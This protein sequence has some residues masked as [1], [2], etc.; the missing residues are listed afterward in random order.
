[1]LRKGNLLLIFA[2]L[3]IAAGCTSP[4]SQL[5]DG[6]DSNSG[7]ITGG[8]LKP[9]LDKAPDLS[10][11]KVRYFEPGKTIVDEGKI[12][13]DDE[14]FTVTGYGPVD[15]LPAEVK[16][17]S[18]YVTF[19]QPV[20]PLS[21][22]G[23]PSG[24][25]D[26]LTI[27]PPLGGVYRWY[28]T[29][30]LSFDAGED[31]IAQRRYT[32][33]VAPSVRSLGG[34]SLSE[35]FTF[36]FR[37]EPLSIVQIIPGDDWNTDLSDV[38][39]GPARNVTVLFSHPVNPDVVTAYI[40]VVVAGGSVAFSFDRRF[41]AGL[42]LTPE[43]HERALVLRL[44]KEVEEETV[45]EIVL[46]E[47]A[48]SQADYLGS[49]AEQR[50][51][52]MTLGK[53][54]FLDYDTYSW[55]FP[56][57]PEGGSYPVF[58]RFSHPVDPLGLS[59]K[60]VTRPKANIPPEAV[61][62]WEG[63]VMIS[64]L[65]FPPEST[66]TLI[67]SPEIRD[68]YA[69]RLGT[70]VKNKVKVPEAQSYSYFPNT[71]SRMLEAEFPH[72][73]AY[74]YQNVF[75]GVWKIDRITDPYRSFDP[76]E[77][78]AYDFSTLKKNVRHFEVLDL[79][80]WLNE[81]GKGTVGISWN[82]A[83]L[84]KD[85]VRPSW[86]QDDLQ[87]QV[88]DL[89]ITA[90]I[91]YNRILVLVTSL[92]TGEPVA[93][94]EVAIMR[95]QEVKLKAETDRSGVAAFDLEAG[96]YNR[97]FQDYEKEWRDHLR[98]RAKI[99]LDSIEFV[100]N[101]S[102]N[103]YRSGVY[104]VSSP[105]YA[106]H[107]T[108]ET[109]LFTDRGLYRPGEKLMFRGID[110]DL[111]L[112]EYKPYQ[113]AYAVKLKNSGYG[114]DV[115]AAL[116][117]YTSFSGGLYGSFDLPGEMEPGYYVIEYTRPD[118]RQWSAY[119]QIAFF[120]NLNF[121]VRI[122]GPDTTRYLGDTLEYDVHAGYLSGGNLSGGSY[123]LYWTKEPAFFSPPGSKWDGYRFGPL[124]SDQ[125]QFLSSSEGKLDSAGN[126]RAEQ[127]TTA[128]GVAGMPYTYQ[129]EAR[130]QNAG[131]QEI[132][133]KKLS[134]VHP[135][136]FYIG[137]R[138]STRLK[139]ASSA[140][141]STGEELLVAWV[142][143]DP[144]GRLYDRGVKERRIEAELFRVDWKIAQQQGVGG[145]VTTRYEMVEELE[146]SKQIEDG[147]V[148]G[149][150]NFTPSRGGLYRVRLNTVDDTGRSVATGLEFYATG[151]DWIRWGGDSDEIDL[152]TD[153]E[154][155]VPGETANI[156]VKS[157]LPKG[158][159]IVTVEREGIFDEH[160]LDLEGSAQ[161]IGVPIREEY[162]PIVYVSVASYSV[163][164]GAPSHTY[165]TPDLD[166]PKGYFGVVP[167]VVDPSSRRIDIDIET[168]G[169]A[170]LPG[171]KAEIVIRATRMKKP[172]AGAE[173]TFLAVDRGVVDLID[174]H[175]PDP[176]EFF[177]S[178]SKFPLY[179]KGA[180]SRSLLIDP[181]T[182]EVRDQFGGDAEDGKEEGGTRS[183]FVP[184][185]V[186]EPFLITDRDGVARVVFTLP[187]SLTTYRCTAVAV[188]G[189]RFGYSEEELRVQQP[190]N[191][192]SL[193]PK[194]IRVRDTITAGVMV[195][196]MDRSSHKVTIGVESNLVK[197]DGEGEKTVNVKP[198]ATLEV[199]FNLYAEEPG[200]TEV[201]F[202]T[203]S[204]VLTERL[205]RQMTVERPAVRETVTTTG[206]I[207]PGDASPPV[208]GVVI[209][210]YEAV[211]DGKLRITLSPSLL[212][213]LFPAVEYLL[214]YPHGC[215]EQRASRL[216]PV[217]LFGSSIVENPESFVAEELKFWAK[218]QLGSGGFP[219]WP[220]NGDHASYYVTVRIA[221][222]LKIAEA[223]G[224]AIPDTIDRRTLVSY[225][226]RPD[227]WVSSNDYLLLYSLYVQSLYGV[228]VHRQAA[229]F[230]ARSNELNHASHAFL[231][232]IFS[233]LRLPVKAAAALKGIIRYLKPG[234]RSVDLTPKGSSP[235]FFY[236]DI[237]EQLAL[238]LMLQTA[239]DPGSDLTDRI[240]ASLLTERHGGSWTNTAATN[241]ALLSLS[242]L[243]ERRD[244]GVPNMT[245]AVTLDKTEL[246]SG[247]FQRMEDSAAVEIR[248]DEEPVSLVKRDTLLPLE[249]DADGRLYYTASLEY[250]LP[251]E[252]AGVRD[253][254]F[255][256][257][258][259]LE[260]TDGT[261]HVSNIL[262]LG[263]TYRQR[264]VVSTSRRRSYTAITV[265]VP[266][267]AV[268]LDTSFATTGSYETVE[269]EYG[270]R[271]RP[272]EKIYDNKVIYYFDDLAPGSVEV[273]FLFRAVN[274]GVF[275][276][277]P[278]TAECM[279]EP[280]VFG[281]SGG[282]LFILRE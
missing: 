34:K 191:V 253:E 216:M 265:P 273:V 137:G 56:R 101:D 213:G 83:E 239:V 158:R 30:L 147:R 223:K 209:P 175:I 181:V 100:P 108:M 138:V 267:G 45:V 88:T 135:A 136:L 59:G 129:L 212:S 274:R 168:G 222:L 233:E 203:R 276:T 4:S 44:E 131:R 226:A 41:P 185:A 202:V 260:T 37:T 171:G 68:I 269:L 126:I 176:L 244:E 183:N 55:T 199:T 94:A 151:A 124:Q 184:T 277:P 144:E 48:R 112:G 169:I 52:F 110:L 163:R 210:G 39:P 205:V 105:L 198:G 1:M 62:V 225:I 99:G 254:G 53:F 66:Y 69:R 6:P 188:D 104:G 123:D 128:E 145:T 17:P 133:A 227:D 87:L 272:I 46:G 263:E 16:R 67:L 238:L 58:L 33:R 61:S 162:L 81:E 103:P 102:H 211:Q 2:A 241:W 157:P 177:Y 84:D 280:E 154:M 246:W 186:F 220:E 172:V 36:S 249:F 250:D 111:R 279:Y 22:L 256:V 7:A 91:A 65:P 152:Q 242:G 15:F 231:G 204:D 208:E 240:A 26:V 3:F 149:S 252:T 257:Y 148:T 195:T 8:R 132:A 258:T 270:Y 189:D 259:T 116:E 86:G 31:V 72:R 50:L 113:G 29:R 245:A 77:L 115:I 164:T 248:F 95:G 140:F 217:V 197:V 106:V 282:K 178:Q 89:A 142:F 237:V 11:Y 194:K 12:F 228:P 159:Y 201:V 156:L 275:P 139:G 98:I 10:V 160:F 51:T 268:I 13:E 79:D 206:R 63:E 27:D 262:S 229:G 18:I 82:F 21:M 114:G 232:L 166:K 85:G 32:V 107:S 24:S 173:I 109:L 43:M 119:F 236:G 75:D 182:Y 143:V 179:V 192:T 70:E 14:P 141:V 38:P 200:D 218:H 221:H 25:S 255:S 92:S 153:R 80:P 74:E 64:G 155:F 146:D 266:S 174:Y 117:G 165:F 130:V 271:D 278:V 264:V 247:M 230:E 19:S 190:L 78:K 261:P 170:Y 150:V 120:E 28:G 251:A 47:G 215:F 35:P 90:R 73:I 20:V 118:G 49:T 167:L 96:D 122:T 196:N 193:L 57:S 125:R 60:I 224:Y 207:E 134:L 219:F 161:L 93:D 40:D 121:E 23:E 97:Y 9:S 127:R 214:E 5:S 187:D 54:E 243:M 234:T 281:R 42:E 180:D 71:G 235:G 76:G